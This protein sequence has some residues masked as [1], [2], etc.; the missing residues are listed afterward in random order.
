M[1]R[2]SVL[3]LAP[4]FQRFSFAKIQ[5]QWLQYF[6]FFRD[7]AAFRARSSLA[8]WTR[9]PGPDLTVT[10]LKPLRVL[11]LS[12]L[13]VSSVRKAQLFEHPGVPVHL[14]AS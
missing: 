9:P 11:G 5:A 4:S 2:K 1:A 6:R 3:F 8:I 13:G 14:S 12:C 7:P 10:D